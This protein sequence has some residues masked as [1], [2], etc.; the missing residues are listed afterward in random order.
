LQFLTGDRSLPAPKQ[1]QT[2]IALP[3]HCRWCS[4]PPPTA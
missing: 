2:I 4:S 1:P 3:V